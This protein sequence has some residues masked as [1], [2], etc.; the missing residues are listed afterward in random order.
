[1][2]DRCCDG[3]IS[4]LM[5]CSVSELAQPR[6]VVSSGVLSTFQP[7]KPLGFAVTTGLLFL[8]LYI[9]F[10]EFRDFHLSHPESPACVLGASRL[11]SLF[12]LYAAVSRPRGSIKRKLV[13]FCTILVLAV[14]SSGLP[15]SS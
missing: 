4:Y 1:M 11:S 12:Y 14:T 7:L 15:D 6:L 9:V 13:T 3:R 10:D 5:F 2:V 8:A